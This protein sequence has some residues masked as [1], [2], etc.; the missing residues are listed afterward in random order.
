[1]EE[2][3]KRSYFTRAILATP[4]VLSP[5]FGNFWFLASRKTI[6]AQGS[7]LH[8]PCS[9][10]ES[11]FTGLVVFRYYHDR[12]F[13]E[14]DVK[15]STQGTLRTLAERH[16]IADFEGIEFLRRVYINPIT[17]CYCIF[18][19]GEAY[20]LVTSVDMVKKKR[21][22]VR[23][24]LNRVYVYNIN[25]PSEL[26]ISLELF[27]DI[28]IARRACIA[29]EWDEAKHWREAHPFHGLFWSN[30][31]LYGISEIEHKACNSV[32][33]CL[34]VKAK[35]G[36]LAKFQNRIDLYSPLFNSL[37]YPNHTQY[38]EAKLLQ[39]YDLLKLDHI[40]LNVGYE[41]IVDGLINAIIDKVLEVR[42][43]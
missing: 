36:M 26:T 33:T 12:Q 3:K 27:H 21:A 9:M 20:H 41:Y 7:I 15:V 43:K 25:D 30:C 4:D 35:N 2:V 39:I 31:T 32:A 22:Y 38:K 42:P 40:D 13:L 19:A 10:I 6:K 14:L 16:S 28:G 23:K 18:V 5:L 17:N 8:Q 29:M 34:E 37:H 11:G 24:Y 1:M